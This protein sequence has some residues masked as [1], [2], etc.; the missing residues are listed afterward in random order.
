MTSSIFT[1]Q[2]IPTYRACFIYNRTILKVV[3]CQ[4]SDRTINGDAVTH[5]ATLRLGA[6]GGSIY[7]LF[8]FLRTCKFTISN[9]PSMVPQSG[10]GMHQ[11]QQSGQR[12]ERISQETT[13]NN[14]WRNDWFLG[15]S[16]RFTIKLAPVWLALP[17]ILF[18]LVAS[19][20][21]I[22]PLQRDVFNWD[23]LTFVV[24]PNLAIFGMP[25]PGAS[26]LILT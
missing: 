16:G 24:S 21:S 13:V 6:A 4:Q 1:A 25:S 17:T 14:V 23:R 22:T 26:Q 20:A 2:H 5:S 3:K 10:H 7:G 8:T 9:P 18:I 19:L 12:S 15:R 11:P